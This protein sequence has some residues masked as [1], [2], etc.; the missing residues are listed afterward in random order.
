MS[1]SILKIYEFDINKANQMLDVSLK[2]KQIL[3]IDNLRKEILQNSQ[4][5]Q[6]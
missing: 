3:F 1:N 4:H 5:I 2:D 6:S